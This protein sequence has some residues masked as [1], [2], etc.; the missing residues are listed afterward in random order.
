MGCT[1]ILFEFEN[2][3][4]KDL[5]FEDLL[6]IVEGTKPSSFIGYI[7]LGRIL[8]P[9]DSISPMGCT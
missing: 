8:L 6:L 4:D 2:K 5:L 9:P 1:C 3:L 7:F